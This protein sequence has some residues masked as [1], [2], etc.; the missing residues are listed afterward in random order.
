M[1]DRSH[2]DAMA[3][4]FHNDPEV[5]A[6]TLDA[7]LADGDQGELLVTLRQMAKAYG[8]VQAVAKAAKLNPTQLY[9][10][11]SEKGNPEFRSLNALL[12]T[13]G[14]RLAVQPLERSIPHI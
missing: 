1:K 13:M 4:I 8:G 12:R 10:T 11:L 6:A 9:R 5:A 14:L 3:E 2:D 7:I